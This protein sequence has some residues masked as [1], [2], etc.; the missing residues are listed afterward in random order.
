MWAA[1]GGLLCVSLAAAN[2]SAAALY[3]A[4]AADASLACLMTLT[5]LQVAATPPLACSVKLAAV[6]LARGGPLARSLTAANVAPVALYT[7]SAG[8]L[9]VSACGSSLPSAMAAAASLVTQP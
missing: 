8:A 6:P 3:M 4:T 2:E 1:A 5:A 7:V 9:V